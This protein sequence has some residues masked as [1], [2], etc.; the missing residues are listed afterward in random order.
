MMQGVVGDV[1][2]GDLLM[3]QSQGELTMAVE[4]GEKVAQ[5][6]IAQGAKNLIEKAR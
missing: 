6:L 3:A 1:E 2:T 4:I 5:D